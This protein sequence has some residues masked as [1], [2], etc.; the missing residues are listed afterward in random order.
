TQQVIQQ[1]GDPGKDGLTPF[2]ADN[3]NWWLGGVDTG[4]KAQAKDGLTPFIADNGNWW[5][6]GVDT[7]VKAQAK[8]GAKGDTGLGFVAI[9][10]QSVENWLTSNMFIDNTIKNYLILYNGWHG[11]KNIEI[12]D[13]ENQQITTLTGDELVGK[14]LTL[15]LTSQRIYIRLNGVLQKEYEYVIH[16]FDIDLTLTNIKLLE[17]A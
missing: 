14:V 4:V 2:I 1:K 9:F 16:G 11:D 12:K 17:L 13:N 7:G 6:G 8:D 3:G 15:Q 10:N 5:L